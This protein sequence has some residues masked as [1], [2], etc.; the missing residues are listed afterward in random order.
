MQPGYFASLRNLFFAFLALFLF[1]F[2]DI[3]SDLLTRLLNENKFCNSYLACR[4][5]GKGYEND[6]IGKPNTQDPD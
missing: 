1:F 5:N 4:Y 3:S 2:F 6:R